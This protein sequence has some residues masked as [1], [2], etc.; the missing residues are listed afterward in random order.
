MKIKTI[1]LVEDDF[2]NRRLSKKTLL[3]NGYGVV[4]AKNTREAASH[5]AKEE[6]SLVVL[7]INLGENEPDGISFGRQLRDNYAIPFIY[8]TAYDNEEIITHAVLTTPHA[9]LTKPYKSTDLL[10]TVKLAMLKTAEPAAHMRTI[11]VKEGNFQA[12]L[13]VNEID[14]IESEGNY[15]SVYSDSKQFKLR[16]TLKQLL[17]MLPA[18]SFAQTHRAFVINK[19]KIEKFT[20][21][22]VIIKGV[23]IPIS[24]SYTL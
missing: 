16:T 24:K 20:N 17:D 2:L 4:E 21:K 14:Y 3:E 12:H 1:L 5:L 18:T 15:L 9:Y 7:D 11:L 22:E 13:P 19:T 6:I 10:T 23:S 8:V